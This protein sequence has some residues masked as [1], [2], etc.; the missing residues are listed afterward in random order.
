V[1]GVCPVCRIGGGS[2]PPR[3]AAETGDA[4]RSNTPC[5]THPGPPCR[6]ATP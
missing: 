5:S 2:T 4:A 6:P 3:F 1:F